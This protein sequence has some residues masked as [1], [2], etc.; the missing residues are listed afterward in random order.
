[1]LRLGRVWW[2][3]DSGSRRNQRKPVILG[4]PGGVQR[5]RFSLVSTL[6]TLH[7]FARLAYIFFGIEELT[8]LCTGFEFGAKR[9]T[10]HREKCES[11][12]VFDQFTN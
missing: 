11:V 7:S 6:I 1:M 10:E 12:V 2:E 3:T 9:H 5:G 4:G 8:K